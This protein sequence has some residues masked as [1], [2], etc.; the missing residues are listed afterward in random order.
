MVQKEKKKRWVGEFHEPAIILII[1][2]S[3]DRAKDHTVL[4]KEKKKKK[5]SEG[6]PNKVGQPS[7]ESSFRGRQMIADQM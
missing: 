2:D 6:A 1:P 5:H 7:V 3:V 4:V